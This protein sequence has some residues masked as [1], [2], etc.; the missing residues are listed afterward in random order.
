MICFA[1]LHCQAPIL[2]DDERIGHSVTCENCKQRLVVPDPSLDGEASDPVPSIPERPPA[3]RFPDIGNGHL[4]VIGT[5]G[6]FLSVLI[7]L[8]YWG[9][10]T[11]AGNAGSG[12]VYNSGKMNDRIV[13]VIIGVGWTIASLLILSA[14][15]PPRRK[16]PAGG[17]RRMRARSRREL[18]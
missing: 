9:M 8:A 5:V 10:D 4:L 1:C 16:Q 11:S 3:R 13:G 12:L 15:R 17:S 2:A 7:T 18:Q 6:L 14:S